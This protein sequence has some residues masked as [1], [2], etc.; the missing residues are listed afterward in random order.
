MSSMNNTEALI[1]MTE[2]NLIRKILEIIKESKDLDDA[3]K[4]VRALLNK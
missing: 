2:D 4:K 1:A 3:E